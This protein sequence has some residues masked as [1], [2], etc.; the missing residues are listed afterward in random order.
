MYRFANLNLSLNPGSYYLSCNPEEAEGYHGNNAWL[1]APASG[2]PG[3]RK[4]SYNPIWTPISQYLMDDA[5]LAFCIFAT[6]HAPAGYD[7]LPGDANMINGQWPPKVI[8]ADVTYLV[9]YFRG[10]NGQCLVGGFYNA[11]DANGDCNIIGSDVTRLVSY[12]RGLSDIA[13]CADY[14]PAWLVP[15]DCPTEAPDG[16]PNCEVVPGDE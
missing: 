2:L 10:I 13:Y 7:Y 4:N 1:T 9:G 8:G 5:N 15:D 3:Y 6:P 14:T 12:F 11:G 16:W